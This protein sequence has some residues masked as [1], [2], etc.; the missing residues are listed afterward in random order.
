M[1][2]MHA[3]ASTHG[4]VHAGKGF[5]VC[6]VHA[7]KGFDVNVAWSEGEMGD[8]EYLSAFYRVFMPIATQVGLHRTPLSFLPCVYTVGLRLTFTG[9]LCSQHVVSA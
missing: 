7:G 2:T 9:E 6:I 1:S 3:K 4:I 5:N 8:A